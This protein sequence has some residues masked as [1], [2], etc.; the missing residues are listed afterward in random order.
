MKTRYR[1]VTAILIVLS[2]VA[3]Y[4]PSAE[5]KE[6]VPE[7]IV[8]TVNGTNI[9][10]SEIDADIEQ[11]L[12]GAPAQMPPE[13]LAQI[14]EQMQE[15][16]VDNFITRTVLAQECE[17]EKITVTPLEV[18]GALAEMSKNLPKGMTLEDA[19]KA[20]G[21]T[22]DS[23]EKDIS[24]GLRVNKLIEANVQ[25][26][27]PPSEADLK[28]FYE[29]NKQSFEV[30]ESV[31]ARHILVKSS[32]DDDPETRAEKKAHA[33]ALRTQLVKGADFAKTATE[34]SDCPS[35][36]RG[37]ELGSFERGRMAK[38]FEDAAFS[39]KAGEIGP[40][41]E[42]KFGYHIILVEKHNPAGNKT[43]E[44]GR[45][46]IRQHLE[47]KNKNMVVREYIDG[48]KSR[49]TIVYPKK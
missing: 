10:Q 27:P 9:T 24:F 42:T 47:Q 22:R 12:A 28:A 44:E 17:K 32:R 46:Q 6:T 34:N 1:A 43:F 3:L 31:Q 23:L 13:Q 40:V 19:L 30:Q 11:K 29:Q 49:A 33:E 37:G 21:L 20:G 38:E 14:R 26:P 25:L 41:V 7:K 45:D 48:L 36:S 15:K 39:Q 18:D 5:A 2:A 4:I 16:A 8:V 35:K